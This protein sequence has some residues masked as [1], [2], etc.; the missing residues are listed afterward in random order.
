MHCATTF[1]TV[2][3]MLSKSINLLK[4]D[5]DFVWTKKKKLG[6]CYD[7]VDDDDDAGIWLWREKESIFLYVCMYECVY[8]PTYHLVDMVTEYTSLSWNWMGEYRENVAEKKWIDAWLY[9][10]GCFFFLVGFILCKRPLPFLADLV[11]LWEVVYFCCW[12]CSHQK[13]EKQH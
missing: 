5:L 2:F 13:V 8:M 11:I 4:R 9:V 10:Y 7:I 6:Y 12:C 3:F 1:P